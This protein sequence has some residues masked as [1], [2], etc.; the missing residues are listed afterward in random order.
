MN[1]RPWLYGLFAAAIGAAGSAI[2]LVIIAPDTFNLSG[3]GLGKL[4]EACAANMLIAVGLYL[5]ATP[6]PQEKV[7]TTTTTLETN[8]TVSPSPD[9]SSK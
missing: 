1:W 8:T 5:K 2:P 3:G 4:G 9:N 6:L 7:T